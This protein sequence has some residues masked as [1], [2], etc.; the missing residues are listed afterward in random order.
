MKKGIA[1]VV[2][3]AAV[4]VGVGPAAAWWHGPH[5]W[6]GGPWYPYPYYAPPVVVQPSPPI[7]VQPSPQPYVQQPHEATPAQSYWYYCDSSKSYYPY[8]KECPGG[9][10]RVSPQP[11]PAP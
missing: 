6:V 2:A 10:Q 4:F 9:W 8:V 1:L 7:V 5:V 3:L 11:S